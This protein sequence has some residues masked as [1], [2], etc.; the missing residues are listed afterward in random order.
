MPSQ[1]SIDRLDLRSTDITTFALGGTTPGDGAGKH[2]QM[3]VTNNV[4]L[5][6]VICGATLT[7]LRAAGR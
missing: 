2:D 4:V 1:Q 5:D 7:R 3:V 6:G